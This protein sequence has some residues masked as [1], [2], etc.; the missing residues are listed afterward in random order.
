VTEEDIFALFEGMMQ[1][2]FK[3]CLGWDVTL[4]FR[5]MDYD[6][7]FYKYG[8]DKPDVRFDMII[9]D[10]GDVLKDSEF[11]VF[12]SALEAGGRI[13]ALVAPG[14][15]SLSR[16]AIDE[17]TEH[18]G[19]YG[20][21]GLVWA[22]VKEGA[23]ESPTAKFFTA[24][25]QQA[26]FERCGAGEG[27]MVFIIA[28][29]EKVCYTSLGQLRL[30]LGRRLNLI[31]PNLFSFLWVSKFPMFEFSEEEQRY[32]AMHHP[33]TAPLQEDIDLLGTGEFHRARARAYDMVL[34]GTELGGGSI[35]IHNRE[36]QKQVFSRLG[37][38][39]QEAEEKFGFL[40]DAFQYG[41]PP[42][43]GIAFGLDRL[44]ML[45]LRL[46]SIREV[47]PFPKTSAGLSLMDNAPDRVDERQL[48]E[49]GIALRNQDK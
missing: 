16:K 23:M 45:M 17:L 2:I 20:A 33:F 43:C 3:Q 5:R 49:L 34:N 10:L 29:A 36:L 4:P 18:V 9:S 40:L 27:D 24:H 7:A 19:R 31:D 6:E 37:I 35:R 28:A 13:A 12:S 38:G 47:I 21:K 25:Q 46:D 15:A 26:I 11:K 41:A 44:V 8:S 14:G 30:E 39:E 22:R 48:Q 1:H 32:M 42:H